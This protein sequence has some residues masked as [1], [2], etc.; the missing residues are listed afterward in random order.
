[1]TS[2]ARAHAQNISAKVNIAGAERRGRSLRASS[3]L[4]SLHSTFVPVSSKNR[5]FHPLLEMTG[6]AVHALSLVFSQFQCNYS[7]WG[8]KPGNEVH[9]LP[10]SKA[11]LSSCSNQLEPRNQDF[12]WASTPT[13]TTTTTR[14]D[15]EKV[16]AV[17]T[18]RRR[19]WAG[20]GSIAWSY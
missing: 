5:H 4:H 12:G 14:S 8:H 18:I 1:M 2:P 16:L 11:S 10:P 17:L 6:L 20:F 15:T 7:H 9:K 19:H 3:V 13:T